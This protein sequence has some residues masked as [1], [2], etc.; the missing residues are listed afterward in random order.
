MN[1]F[2]RGLNKLM[3]I[4]RCDQNALDDPPMVNE[5]MFTHEGTDE[6]PYFPCWIDNGIG[7]V[8]HP[9]ELD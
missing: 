4:Q 8:R 2:G 5:N 7:E 3:G 6:S 1:V 9:V